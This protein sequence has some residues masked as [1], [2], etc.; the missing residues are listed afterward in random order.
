MPQKIYSYDGKLD[1]GEE[2]RPDETV[3]VES[4]GQ[5]PLSPARNVEVVGP[6][7]A[8]ARLLA[9]RLVGKNGVAGSCVHKK[10]PL[11]DVVHNED[12]LARGNGIDPPPAT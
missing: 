9:S 10:T 1:L 5:L 2:E 4:H 11:G 3:A 8:R 7:E 6:G 12:E